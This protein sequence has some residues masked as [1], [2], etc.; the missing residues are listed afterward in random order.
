MKKDV[1]QK[2]YLK[3]AERVADILNGHFFHGEKVIKAEDVVIT[4][5]DSFFFKMGKETSQIVK[6][7]HDA[8]YNIVRGADCFI[9]GLEQQNYID[10]AMVLRSLE[11]MTGQYEEQ[12]HEI[13][14][15]HEREQDLKAD[16]HISRFSIEDRLR[17]VIILVIYYGDSEWNGARTLHELLDWSHIP[18]KWKSMFADYQLHLLEVNKIENLDIYHSDLKLLFGIL[19]YRRDKEKL[20]AFIE[21][22]MEEFS[23]VAT[24]LARVIGNYSHTKRILTIIEEKKNKNEGGTL[25]MIPAFEEMVEDGRKEGRKEGAEQFGRLT[26]CLLSD[27]RMEDLK[28]A[29]EDEEYR[30][31]L[32]EEYEI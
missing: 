27:C 11:Y 21:D 22:N 12:R 32:L 26:R 5:G 25:N 16:E 8:V 17:P 30:E 2:H 15:L 4:D 1:T 6:R 20:A 13:M 29:I 31:K 24:D 7:E 3:D 18:E 14:R 10:P 28:R 9:L 23:K 19:K